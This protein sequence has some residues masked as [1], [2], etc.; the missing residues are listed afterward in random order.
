MDHFATG[1]PITH[2]PQIPP[3]DQPE[4][5]DLN[6]ISLPNLSNVLITYTLTI[7]GILATAL[8]DTGAQDCYRVEST[9][10]IFLFLERVTFYGTTS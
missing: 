2:A 8:L 10:S 6:E 1:P 5:P 4:I 9:L 3:P 7:N